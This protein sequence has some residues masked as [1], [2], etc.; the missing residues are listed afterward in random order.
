MKDV[1]E[2]HDAWQECLI[3]IRDSKEK[4]VEIEIE[5]EFFDS[6]VLALPRLSDNREN[7]VNEAVARYYNKDSVTVREKSE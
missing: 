4:D 5:E 2:I 3:A 7:W 1:E 6:R